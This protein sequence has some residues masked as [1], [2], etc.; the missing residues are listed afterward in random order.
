[1]QG[2]ITALHRLPPLSP[3]LE[4]SLVAREEQRELETKLERKDKCRSVNI[5]QSSRSLSPSVS[6]SLSLSIVIFYN[7]TA[8]SVLSAPPDL[9]RWL[10][11]S[12]TKWM[13]RGSEQVVSSGRHAVS[14]TDMNLLSKPCCELCSRTRQN[15]TLSLLS[16]PRHYDTIYSITHSLSLHQ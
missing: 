9:L 11:D 12:E 4:W 7:H 13:V 6:V 3:S 10:P 14:P 5:K 2:L 1:M 8:I 15:S 16:S